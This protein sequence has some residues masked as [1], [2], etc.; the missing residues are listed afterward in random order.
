[1]GALSDQEARERAARESLEA[2]APRD[3]TDKQRKHWVT[4]QLRKRAAE[5]LDPYEEP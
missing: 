2:Q 5:G 3:L 4:D 1:M